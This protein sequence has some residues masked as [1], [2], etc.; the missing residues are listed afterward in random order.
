MRSAIATLSFGNFLIGTGAFVVAGLTSHIAR[1]FDVTIAAAAQLLTIY[2][3]TYALSAPFL[4]TLASG[5]ARRLALAMA[6]TLFSA[7]NLVVAVADSFG[8]LCAGRIMAALGAALFSPLAYA[9]AAE[10]SLPE[11]RARALS[12]VIL[13]LTIANVV[14]VPI[15]AA[16]G[17]TD[18]WRWTFVAVGGLGLAASLAMLVLLPRT[19]LGPARSLAAIGQALSRPVVVA[20]IAVSFLHYAAVFIVFAYLAPIVT[21]GRAF[22]ALGVPWLLFVFGCGTIAG[23]LLGG[24]AAD[25]WGRMRVITISLALLVPILALFPLACRSATA[26]SIL[27]FAWGA[28]GLAFMAPQQHRLISL[29]GQ[30]APVLLSLNVSAIYLGGAAGAVLGAA[31]EHLGVNA[32]GLAGAGLAATAVLLSTAIAQSPSESQER[33]RPG[34]SA[35]AESSAKAGVT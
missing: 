3:L 17:A 14:G 34:R 27:A 4:T 10:L 9:S 19:E 16:A 7:G 23:N 25:R 13:G 29:P 32:F 30:A 6:M 21:A 26:A 2:T 24:W 33:L 8:V 20:T 22:G 18:G 28:V 11:T 31:V 5:S 1:D 12:L 35:A 15:G